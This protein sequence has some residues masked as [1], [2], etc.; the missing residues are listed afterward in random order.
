MKHQLLSLTL[1]FCFA[2]FHFSC[3]KNST[4][5]T[6]PTKTQLLTS[7]TWKFSSATV[8]GTDVSGYLQ[9]CQKDNILTFQSVGTGSLD[10]GAA[11]CNSGDP[12]TNPFT[13]NFAS[14]ETV[15]HISTVLF[16]GGNSDFTIVSLTNT[17]LVVSQNITVSGT[18]QN[19]VVTFVH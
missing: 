6:P 19:A 13:W 3:Q 7:I 1:C 14:N 16:T 2:A 17:S 11:K 15:L 10:E 5:I 12:Q 18:T 8:S 9:T 4:Q